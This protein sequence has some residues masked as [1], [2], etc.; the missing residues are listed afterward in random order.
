VVGAPKVPFVTLAPEAI[1]AG[2]AMEL[3]HPV[4]IPIVGSC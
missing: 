1:V 4:Q 3:T 2:A